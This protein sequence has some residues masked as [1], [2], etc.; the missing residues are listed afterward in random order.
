MRL[1]HHHRNKQI[2]HTCMVLM[3]VVQVYISWSDIDIAP[4]RQLVGAKRLSSLS[5][6]QTAKVRIF[7][8]YICQFIFYIMHAGLQLEGSYTSIYIITGDVYHHFG[9]DDAV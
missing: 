7:N 8:F 6:S 3:Q 4:I 2:I 9:A 1:N 5:P